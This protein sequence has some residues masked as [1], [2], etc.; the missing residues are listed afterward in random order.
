VYGEELR[1][2][3]T[4]WNPTVSGCRRHPHTLVCRHAQ[5]ESF[6]LNF[7][8]PEIMPLSLND[9][10][11]VVGEELVGKIHQEAESLVDKHVEHINSTFYGGGVAEILNSLTLLMNDVGIKTGWRLLKG[12]QDFFNVTKKFHN[13]LQSADIE[14]SDTKKRIYMET[15]ETNS[16]I[17]HID[18]ADCI[19]I[20]DPQPLPLINFY[21]KNQSW[22]WRCHIDLSNPNQTLWNYLKQFIEKYDSSIFSREEYTKKDLHIPHNIIPPSIDPLT[23]KNKFIPESVCKT[24]LSRFGVD[25]DKPIISQVSRF[26]VWKDPL[27]VIKAFEIIKKQVD[28]K[29]VL[30][31]SM[32]SDDPEG[33]EIYNKLMEK[34]KDNPDIVII[35]FSDDF[36]VNCLQRTS[37]VVIQKSLKEGFGLTVTEALWKGTPVIGGNVGGIPLQVLDGKNGFLVNDVNECAD[38]TIK[39][40]KDPKLREDMGKAGIEHVKN[41]FL[42]TRHMMDYIML[43]KGMIQ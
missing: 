37:D 6:K 14:L 28:C 13:A 10:K 41:N 20:H 38:R 36:L 39:L 25:L 30:L 2:P 40:L 26:D 23:T 8:N 16:I 27:G 24:Y 15:N 35:N 11:D 19:I 7:F 3:E 17:M 9:Y 18:S 5:I 12:S 1:S 21:K 31:G 22:I 43:L 34:V 4:A 42:I 32:A 29:L 33:E